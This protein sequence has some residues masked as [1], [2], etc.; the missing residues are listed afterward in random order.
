MESAGIEVRLF[1][2]V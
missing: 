2:Y 1:R